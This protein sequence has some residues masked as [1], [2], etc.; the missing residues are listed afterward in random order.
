ML[1]H[2]SNE[3][4]LRAPDFVEGADTDTI[5][6]GAGIFCP[7]GKA[8]FCV[9]GPLED[10]GIVADVMRFRCLISPHDCLTGTM[11][12]TFPAYSTKVLHTEFNGFIAS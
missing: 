1:D 2:P 11:F 9:Y 12:C 5:H 6:T 3:I 7:E 4:M 8:S 10:S